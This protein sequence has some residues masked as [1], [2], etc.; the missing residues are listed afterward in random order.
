[1]LLT[2]LFILNFAAFF[3]FDLQSLFA[4]TGHDLLVVH[5]FG[6]QVFAGR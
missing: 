3:L 1:M 4:K 6:A 5:H 2:S